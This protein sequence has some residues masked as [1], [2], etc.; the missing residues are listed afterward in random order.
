MNFPSL[1]AFSQIWK[2]DFLGA[3]PKL[4]SVWEEPEVSFCWMWNV[5]LEIP[6]KWNFL[7]FR[8]D[9][10]SNYQQKTLQKMRIL[11]PYPKISQNI[12]QGMGAGIPEVFKSMDLEDLGFFICY[13]Y[14]K[15]FIP[16][17]GR[18]VSCT[19]GVWGIKLCTNKSW[20]VLGKMGKWENG[21]GRE[22]LGW[23][24]W[25]LSFESPAGKMTN[26]TF[27]RGKN[28]IFPWKKWQIITSQR[29]NNPSSPWVIITFLRGKKSPFLP[30]K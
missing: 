17:I 1:I 14:P 15:G 29:E 25:T 7:S 30:G 9:F 13:T 28:P 20:C 27:L 11:N 4:W 6:E 3:N 26:S 10:P 8:S 16:C 23:I 19:K 22:G 5:S 21:A 12:Q 24:S 2:G 18:F